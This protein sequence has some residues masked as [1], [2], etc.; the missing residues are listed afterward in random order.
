M[1][2]SGIREVMDLAATL[3]DVI[4]L[5]LG[6]PDFPTPPHVIEAVTR[7]LADGA[8]KYTLSRGVPQ[9]REL[10]AA[11]VQARN[12]IEAGR[13]EVV[14]TTGGTTAVLEALLACVQPGE[15]VL[16]PDPGWP[17]FAMAT[18]LAGGRVVRY[19]LRP[20]DGYEP[21]LEALEGMAS[22]A[23]V[24]IINTPSNPTGAVFSRTTVE[25]LVEIAQRHD[26][27][28]ISDEVYEDL[29]FE[30][31]H[32]SA[33]S[34]DED[35]R[36]ITV[37]SFSKAYAMTGWRIG[38]AVAPRLLADAIVRVQ[39]AVIA[40]PAD[41]AQ[42][43]AIAALEGPHEVVEQMCESYRQRRDLA[44][45]PLREAGMLAGDPRGTFYALADTRAISPDGYEVARRLLLER[46]VG[47]AP[48]ETFGPAAHGLV[49]I[50]LATSAPQL[51]EG[52]RRIVAAARESFPTPT[53][54]A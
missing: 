26:L 51:L 3:E 20:E 45:A 16:V 24:L 23:R 49:R 5:E 31:E 42:R 4:H 9:L 10:I 50:S 53:E 43:A 29:I 14:V 48:G 40:C 19:P 2:R 36:V 46:R 34:C 38:Y 41:V 37:F 7:G 44:T 39:E 18:H 25:Q 12:G 17:T 21:D 27:L 13:D 52:V 47:V 1:G 8:V 28:V 22:D 15:G 54:E 35:E 32:V 6:E 30:G 11:K 33:A